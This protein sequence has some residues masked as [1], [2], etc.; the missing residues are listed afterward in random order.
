[1]YTAASGNFITQF[2]IYEIVFFGEVPMRN[3]TS[4]GWAFTAFPYGNIIFR[5]FTGWY[6]FRGQVGQFY[7]LLLQLFSVSA[8]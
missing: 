7:D 1:M 2:K 5:C 4:I 8:S 3:S 6:F